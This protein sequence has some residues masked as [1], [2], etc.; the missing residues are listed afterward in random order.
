VP[1]SGVVPTTYKIT[2]ASSLECTETFVLTRDDFPGQDWESDYALPV[3]H[4]VI[5]ANVVNVRTTSHASTPMI[6][7]TTT[8]CKVTPKAGN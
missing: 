3:L 2:S 4:R 7:T 8:A 5:G 1:A 6:C